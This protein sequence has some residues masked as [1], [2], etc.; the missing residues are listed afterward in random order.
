[1][2][3]PLIKRDLH[4]VATKDG[5]VPWASTGARL[6]SV[7]GPGGSEREAFPEAERVSRSGALGR[8]FA[9]AQG[10]SRATSQGGDG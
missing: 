3:D 9:E 2:E 6:L 1:M 4:R 8:H 10:Q 5:V 7:L